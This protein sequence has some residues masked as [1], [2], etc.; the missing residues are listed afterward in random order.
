MG[1]QA[2]ID[3][4][5]LPLEALALL[6]PELIG[7]PA[8]LLASFAAMCA[9]SNSGV[10]VNLYAVNP[11]DGS[12]KWS[13]SLYTRVSNCASNS[14]P[15]LQ[16]LNPP[17]MAEDGT[18]YVS[19]QT[20]WAVSPDGQQLWDVNLGGCQGDLNPFEAEPIWALPSPAIGPDGT[21]YVTARQ[22]FNSLG[23]YF[24]TS[25]FL[26][27]LNPADGSQKWWSDTGDNNYGMGSF[28]SV[29][30]AISNSGILYVGT[31]DNSLAAFNSDGTQAWKL[32][33]GGPIVAPPTLGSDGTIFV[34][35]SD[36]RIYS[37]SSEGT[38]IWSYSMSNGL[39][40]SALTK[41]GLSGIFS[42][43][44]IGANG[45]LYFQV[46]K[47]AYAMGLPEASY[48]SCTSLALGD[49]SSTD[50]LLPC[51]TSCPSGYA[52]ELNICTLKK[53]SDSPTMTPTT[54]IPSYPPTSRPT[55][56]LISFIANE[57]PGASEARSWMDVATSSDGTV[58][59]ALDSGYHTSDTV[60]V[61]I[62]R[63]GGVTWSAHSPLFG[64]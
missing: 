44:A 15:L 8:L 29:S 51:V 10:D 34:G 42:S 24:R 54:G 37:V 26:F 63:D 47:S 23:L 28:D 5:V 3:M 31:T 50:I 33:L 30:V 6:Q 40:S 56:P 11:W 27:A 14:S 45:V 61:Q 18:I 53:A 35:S 49:Y 48:A 20:V 57:S 41:G 25:S 4:M 13:L 1:S 2:I 19:L 36:M 38:L 21:L 55:G 60:V 52:N 7:I 64:E 12:L 9:V 39:M 16:R 22:F 59:A 58:L 46:G 43:I 17:S 62:S 32:S